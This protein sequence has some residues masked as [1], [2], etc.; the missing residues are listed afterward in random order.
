MTTPTPDQ[1]VDLADWLSLRK[2]AREAR[3]T[4]ARSPMS[5]FVAKMRE[6]IADYLTAREQGVSREAAVGGIEEV[7]RAEWPHRP[8]KFEQCGSCDDTGWRLTECVHGM[9]CGRKR[10]G[11]SESSWWHSY[12]VPC[13]CTSGDKHRKK[14]AQMEDDLANVG[15]VKSRK[16]SGG[17]TRAGG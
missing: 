16:R 10:C 14:V 13:E 3:R 9:R 5:R 12:A 17:F 7:L 15:K 1:P 8:S 6:V 4:F 2:K 11:L